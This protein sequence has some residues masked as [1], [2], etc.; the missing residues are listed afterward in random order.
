[1]H[2]LATCPETSPALC[3]IRCALY[4]E[5]APTQRAGS[6]GNRIKAIVGARSALSE[7]KCIVLATFPQISPALCVIRCALYT[8]RAPTQ[9]AGSCGNRIKANVGARSALSTAKC[10][11]LA[12]FPQI[13]PALCVIRCALYTERAPT[14]KAGSY[15]SFTGEAVYQ[16][17]PSCSQPSP[18]PRLNTLSLSST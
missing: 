17:S 6:C 16:T 2:E 13:S 1:M 9:R 10:I 11:E 8:E 18:V 15:Q 7:A 3:V 14:H 4:T 5:R 12:T